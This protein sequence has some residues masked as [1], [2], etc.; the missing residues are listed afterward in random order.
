[1]SLVNF[2]S[3]VLISSSR[4]KTTTT[5]LFSAELTKSV[6]KAMEWGEQELPDKA[7]GI[8]MDGKLAGGTF[9]LAPRQGAQGVLDGIAPA[10]LECGLGSCGHFQ[11]VRREIE[12][13]RG[14]GFRRE[15]RFKV[16]SSDVDASAKAEAWLTTIGETKGTLKLNYAAKATSAGD[17]GEEEGTE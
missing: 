3:A 5:L 4:T 16:T 1:M 6:A 8:K 10:E 15:L 12:Q 17:D 2:S 13:S 14:K 7:S 11:I 9:S